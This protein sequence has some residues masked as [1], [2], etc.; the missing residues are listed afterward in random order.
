M[1]IRLI[2]SIASATLALACVALAITASAAANVRF[3]PSPER[4]ERIAAGPG[5]LWFL[6]TTESSINENLDYMGATGA[7]TSHELPGEV[8][9]NGLT[10]GPEGAVWFVGNEPVYGLSIKRYNG[11]GWG[12]VNLARDYEDVAL[13][14]SG[15]VWALFRED[16][17]AGETLN[18]GRLTIKTETDGDLESELTEYPSSHVSGPGSFGE[19]VLATDDSVWFRSNISELAH[20]ASG[21][22]SY[23]SV[24]DP[25]APYINQPIDLTA[26][27]NAEVWFSLESVTEP[28]TAIGSITAGGVFRVFPLPAGVNL[29]E[30]TLGSD[31]DIWFTYA[32][33]Q[34]EGINAGTIGVGKMTPS[35][36]FTY[37]P[38]TLLGGQYEP[39]GGLAGEPNGPVAIGVLY[40]PKPGALNF[41][42][43]RITPDTPGL[44]SPEISASGAGAGPSP[45]AGP[46]PTV[47]TVKPVVIPAQ[48][49]RSVSRLKSSAQAIEPYMTATDVADLA[50][51]LA[52]VAA[53]PELAPEILLPG[54][55]M[56]TGMQ[57]ADAGIGSSIS[58]IAS[59]PPDPHYKA[60]DAVRPNTAPTLHTKRGVSTAAAHAWNVMIANSL[61]SSAY[62]DALV[63][64][65]ERL[66]GA[67]LA[68]NCLWTRRQKRT[69]H[70]YALMAA[71]DLAREQRLVGAVEH[72][73]KAHALPNVVVTPTQLEQAKAVLATAGL[74]RDVEA[75]LRHSGATSADISQLITAVLTWRPASLS[76]AET[77]ASR[78]HTTAPLLSRI[79]QFARAL[80]TPL[81]CPRPAAHTR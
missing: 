43:L 76:V 67:A 74:P 51:S 28:G 44:P 13:S 23:F 10:V 17:R 45:V 66:D 8:G 55:T 21:S 34:Y 41:G 25:T 75:T 30:S 15:T 11:G 72:D 50:F 71:R 38:P 18:V 20:F 9:E 35:G 73:I 2:R 65:N 56:E 59:D 5:G 22:Y 81:S 68:G 54:A 6:A 7:I 39:A 36:T 48:V 31:G 19:M 47:V 16:T 27:P 80:A 33:S 58:T 63:A 64:A 77:L 24:A 49:R 42:I 78:V 4:P 40:G 1:C 79:R 69:A 53:A 26:G 46:S 12:E 57:I 29:I 3:F 14:A 62:I 32:D 61:S 70:L 37:Y 60:I 52:L